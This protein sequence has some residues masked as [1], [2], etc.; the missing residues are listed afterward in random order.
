[1]AYRVPNKSQE[2]ISARTAIGVSIPFSKLFHQT[3]T[4]REAVRS[5]LINYLLTDRGER[6]LNPLFGS[7]I[8]KTLFDP[9][10]KDTLD[11][12]ELQ[13]REGIEFFFPLI[14]IKNLIITPNLNFNQINISLTY[15]V[16]NNELDEVNIDFNTD[17]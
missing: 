16:Y 9:I 14:A 7:D 15:S 2:D 12:L 1:M 11:G 5:N 17:E 8:K 10:V 13:V 4:T 3:Y 6:P